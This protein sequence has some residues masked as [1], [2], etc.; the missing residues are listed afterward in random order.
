MAPALYTP[1]P[2]PRGSEGDGTME[3]EL[4]WSLFEGTCEEVHQELMAME[5]CALRK[6]PLTIFYLLPP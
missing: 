1:S 2:A 6:Q 4:A 3:Q 5:P